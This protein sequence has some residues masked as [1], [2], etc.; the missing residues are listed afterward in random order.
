[1]YERKM[2]TGKSKL[3]N[4]EICRDKKKKEERKQ[5]KRRETRTKIVILFQLS[6][7]SIF[8]RNAKAGQTPV[9]GIALRG[10]TN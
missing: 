8:M 10:I 3:R 1:M 5:K 4:S 7:L 9:L 2:K 6:Y